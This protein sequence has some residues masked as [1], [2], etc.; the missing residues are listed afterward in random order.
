MK[1]IKIIVL[2]MLGFLS[3]GLQAVGVEGEGPRPESDVTA[4]RNQEEANKNENIAREAIESGKNEGQESSKSEKVGF[5][6]KLLRLID[7]K[8]GWSWSKLSK[9]TQRDAKH[10]AQQAK[11]LKDVTNNPA[12]GDAAE[13]VVAAAQ[14]AENSTSEQVTVNVIEAEVILIKAAKNASPEDQADIKEFTES[15][16]PLHKEVVEEMAK[17]ESLPSAE[18]SQP[19]A[20]KEQGFSLG[21]EFQSNE[22]APQSLNES[23]K[24]M[25]LQ[26]QGDTGPTLAQMRATNA[27]RPNPFSIPKQAA[28]SSESIADESSQA[29]NEVESN[30]GPTLAQIKAMNASRPNPFGIPKQT[31]SSSE[32]TANEPLQVNNEAESNTGPS[33]A[34]LKAMRAGRPNPF[35]APKQSNSNES[36]GTA[37]P[38]PFGGGDANPFA[39]AK[40]RSTSG[41]AQNTEKVEVKPVKT[42]TALEAGIRKNQ[43]K[44]DAKQYA[45]Q[46]KVAVDAL[47]NNATEEEVSIATKKAINDAKQS[48]EEQENLKYEQE[49]QARAIASEKAKQQAQEQEAQDKAKRLAKA[50]ANKELSANLKAERSASPTIKSNRS[51]VQP[52]NLTIE[53]MSPITTEMME[54]GLVPGSDEY[55]NKKNALIAD[56]MAQ[57]TATKKQVTV[58]KSVLQSPGKLAATNNLNDLFAKRVA[59]QQAASNVDE[60]TQSGEGKVTAQSSMADML[61]KRAAMMKQMNTA[62]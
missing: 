28:P 20:P 8:T 37:R 23:G 30:T 15:L 11:N 18:E 24:G 9:Q 5:F 62:Q 42:E 61:A 29:N 46:I 35:G 1:N 57:K 27:S 50:A 32:P 21:N 53:E 33:M 38:N 4:T 19:N 16:S 12:V 60:P 48:E 2:C 45:E 7:S 25:T 40:L 49:K 22:E 6:E 55:T 34:E 39:G 58:G 14:A 3:Y 41:E 51:R 31:V 56:V 43:E 54:S 52:N 26:E 44:K 47:P 17:D 10:S 13:K 59:P 36:E